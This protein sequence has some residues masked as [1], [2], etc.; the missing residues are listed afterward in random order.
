MS[1]FEAEQFCTRLGLTFG[2]PQSNMA[3]FLQLSS[4]DNFYL[5][6]SICINYKIRTTADNI[7]FWD[8]SFT[9]KNVSMN[10]NRA[11]CM[12]VVK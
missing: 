8:Q 1:R 4:G 9:Y 11:F 10:E 2:L 5:F 7:S 6:R 12:S 3:Q